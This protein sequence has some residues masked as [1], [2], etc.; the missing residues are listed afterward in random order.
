MGDSIA[1]MEL[2]IIMANMV[3]KYRMTFPDGPKPTLDGLR[4]LFSMPHPYNVILSNRE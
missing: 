1:K 2:F 3:Q 4:T